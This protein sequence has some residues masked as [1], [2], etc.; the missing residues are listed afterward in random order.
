M[1][2]YNAV[3]VEYREQSKNKSKRQLEI[4]GSTSTDE[5]LEHMLEVKCFQYLLLSPEPSK[6][7][8]I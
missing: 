7:S 2:E 5:E 6:M 8:L 4:A 3:Q 1:T